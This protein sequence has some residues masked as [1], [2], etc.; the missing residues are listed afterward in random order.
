MARRYRAAPVRAQRLPRGIR[1]RQR[2]LRHRS[3]NSSGPVASAG[4]VSRRGLALDSGT[5]SEAGAGRDRW[6]AASPEPPYLH[7]RGRYGMLIPGSVRASSRLT[8]TEKESLMPAS[9]R[10]FVAV[11]GLGG[12]IAMAQAPDGG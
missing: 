7:G 2:P 8:N 5:L 3:G 11:F 4:P 12:T 10:P 9:A 6:T 1:V